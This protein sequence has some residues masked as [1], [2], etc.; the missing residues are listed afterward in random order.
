AIYPVCGWPPSL[1]PCVRGRRLVAQSLDLAPG[2]GDADLPDPFQLYAGD[3][4]GIETRKVDRG[5]RLSPLD[6]FQ[7]ALAGLQADGSLLAVEA[8]QRVAL[9]AIHYDNV[10][11]LVLWQH[12]IA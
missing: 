7:I 12:G 6:R 5:R 4:L 11:I 3:R 9:F 8:G 10:A 2:Q 1:S